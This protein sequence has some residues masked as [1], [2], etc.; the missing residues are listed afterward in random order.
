MRGCDICPPPIKNASPKVKRAKRQKLYSISNEQSKEVV[1]DNEDGDTGPK[2][3]LECSFIYYLR[4]DGLWLKVGDIVSVEGVG[5]PFI[6]YR[7]YTGTDDGCVLAKL[8]N[9]NNCIL[10]EDFIIICNINYIVYYSGGKVSLKGSVKEK[11]EQDAYVEFCTFMSS[12]VSV[13]VKVNLRK[14]VLGHAMRVGLQG[15]FTNLSCTRISLGPSDVMLDNKIFHFIAL[16]GVV[17]FSLVNDGD[18]ELV[19]EILG[20]GWDYKVGRAEDAFFKFIT[21]VQVKRSNDL[22][23]VLI[24]KFSQSQF[25]FTPGYRAECRKAINEGKE[26]M[27]NIIL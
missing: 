15:G 14:M 10:R 21:E 19:D 22:S 4:D 20:K 7:M 9:V 17:K 25:V 1:A 6:I 3:E 23:L 26:Q 13:V 8:V 16:T 12:N 24:A 27:E 2:D 11:V 5:L 18:F